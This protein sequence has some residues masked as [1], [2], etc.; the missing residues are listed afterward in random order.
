MDFLK[1]IVVNLKAT[2]PSAVLIAWI[3]GI[4]LLGIFGDGEIAKKAVNYLGI[5][6]GILVVVLGQ[7]I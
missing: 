5:L 2:G 4:T 7:R 1:N 3:I 6:G